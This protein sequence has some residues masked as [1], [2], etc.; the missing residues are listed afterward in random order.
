MKL[1]MDKDT[2]SG[3]VAYLLSN[4]ILIRGVVSNTFFSI[5]YLTYIINAPDMQTPP[6]PNTL[7][8]FLHRS[9]TFSVQVGDKR[10]HF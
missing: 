5:P 7:L 1:D 4:L 9:T 6:P 10:N 3:F 8:P 2:E